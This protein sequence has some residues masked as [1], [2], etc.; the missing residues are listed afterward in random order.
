[1]SPPD[2]LTVTIGGEAAQLLLRIGTAVLLAL[3][4]LALRGRVK[5]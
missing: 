1:M 4:T 5:R 2:N 3:A